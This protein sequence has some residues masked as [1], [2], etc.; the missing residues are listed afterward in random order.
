[1]I[2]G[3]INGDNK[4]GQC[5]TWYIVRNARFYKTTDTEDN[6]SHVDSFVEAIKHIYGAVSQRNSGSEF[7]NINSTEFM[8]WHKFQLTFR[9]SNKSFDQV[10]ITGEMVNYYLSKFE[11]TKNR[12]EKFISCVYKGERYRIVG[13]DKT[14]YNLS[15]GLWVDKN[16]VT[17]YKEV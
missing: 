1:M 13:E 3:G 16:L 7:R 5:K 17:Y 6:A 10:T 15:N 14:R 9:G 12:S 11:F 2:Y 4:F 8:K